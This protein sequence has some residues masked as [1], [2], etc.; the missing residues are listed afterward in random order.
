MGAFLRRF[1]LELLGTLLFSVIMACFIYIK[2]LDKVQLELLFPIIKST[3]QKGGGGQDGTSNTCGGKYNVK[4]DDTSWKNSIYSADSIVNTMSWPSSSTMEAWNKLKYIPNEATSRTDSWIFKEIG[5]APY[6]PGTWIKLTTMRSYDTLRRW[7]ISYMGQFYD[8]AFPNFMN[9]MFVQSIFYFSLI[10]V[11]FWVTPF[12][13]LYHAFSVDP[14]NAILLCFCVTPLL[15][16]V[17][18]FFQSV[19]LFFTFIIPIMVAGI[20]L[21]YNANDSIMKILNCNIPSIAFL[22]VIRTII[23]ASETLNGTCAAGIL[24]GLFVY[25]L[26]FK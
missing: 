6:N 18:S 21:K 2:T 26:F 19:Q 8:K 1:G 20:A 7:I 13:T 9:N 11:G 16:V 4:Y 10:F 14:M 5:F 25:L 3:T 17:L 15:V 12:V 22:F 23:N 24:I